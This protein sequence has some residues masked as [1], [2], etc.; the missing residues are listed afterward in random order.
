VT[1]L[2]ELP[3]ILKIS[4]AAAFLRVSK[5]SLHTEIREGRLPVIRVSH[6][7]WRIS[8]VALERW[9]AAQGADTPEKEIEDESD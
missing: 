4:E 8:R 2:A 6:R 9:M 7:V 3:D 1:A 5:H